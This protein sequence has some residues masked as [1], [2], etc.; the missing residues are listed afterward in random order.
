MVRLICFYFLIV[1]Y[2]CGGEG[3]YE[4]KLTNEQFESA[5]LD[6]EMAKEASRTASIGIQDSLLDQYLTI[7]SAQYNLTL[8]EL[9]LETITR[10]SEEEG[11][12]ELYDGL[13]A[14]IDSLVTKNK[15]KK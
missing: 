4:F 13:K 1:C 9:K 6:I 7:I 11:F 14:R 12:E 2:A 5:L 3:N 10:I 8:E 15:S